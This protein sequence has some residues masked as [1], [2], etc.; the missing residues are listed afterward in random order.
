MMMIY[1]YDPRHSIF[2]PLGTFAAFWHKYDK[3]CWGQHCTGNRKLRIWLIRD[4]LETER[5]GLVSILDISDYFSSV[6][7]IRK[8][9][10]SGSG[11]YFL[12]GWNQYNNL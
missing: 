6:F 2:H 10:G 1:E 4:L 3:I 11:L 5:E 7:S 9:D 8:R 12:Q